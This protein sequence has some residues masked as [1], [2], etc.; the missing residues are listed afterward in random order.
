MPGQSIVFWRKAHRGWSRSRRS[1]HGQVGVA[2][3]RVAAQQQLDLI[4]VRRRLHL[5]QQVQH[6]ARHR[7]GR[8]DRSSCKAPG[9]SIGRRKHAQHPL[10]PGAWELEFSHPPRK[11]CRGLTPP[12]RRRQRGHPQA[13]HR[14]NARHGQ[15]ARHCHQATARCRVRQACGRVPGFAWTPCRQA[16]S[17]LLRAAVARWIPSCCL[18]V[19]VPPAGL[20]QPHDRTTAPPH[21]RTTARPHDRTGAERSSTRSRHAGCRRTAASRLG[22]EGPDKTR[23]GPSARISPPRQ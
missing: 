7:R 3:R 11:A 16:G 5:G 12:H 18:N 10:R 13:E 15:E 19:S 21:D 4:P 17:R 23:L 8:E 14:A 6:S 20:R 2:S 9:R 22:W 1:R